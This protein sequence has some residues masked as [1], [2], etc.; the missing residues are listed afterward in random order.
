MKKHILC[1]AGILLFIQGY[2]QPDSARQMMADTL[3]RD[4][5]SPI[6]YVTPEQTPVRVKRE[7]VYTL[8]PVVDIPIIA[9]GTG[10]TL[11]A[12]TKIY[13]KGTSTEEQ[14]SNLNIADVNSFD[15]WAVNPY[16]KS[17]DKF[18]YYPFNASFAYPL[19]MLLFRQD[20]KKDFW[21]LSYLYWEALSVTGLFGAG[22]PFFIDGY[23][24][25]AYSSETPMDQRRVQNAKN[26][27]F[28]GH[29]EVIATSTFFIAKVYSDYDPD[30]KLVMYGVASLATAGMA[31]IR[32]EG[33]MH[34][35]SDVLAGAA[36][37]TLAGILVPQYHK[38]KPSKEVSFRV[39]PYSTG[40]IN[41]LV[42]TCQFNK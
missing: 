27:V 14:I 32:L 11:Y 1:L 5:P 19:V 23:R 6:S 29:V 21:K 12:T 4:T 36:I 40:E 24:P 34:F 39:L 9:I 30:T 20:T 41:G 35:P 33:G 42:F 15:R 10:F 18:S 22:A 38:T 17:L 8:K 25:Y 31:L 26:S 37:G 2:S 3:S 16:S 7:S 28:S 13:T